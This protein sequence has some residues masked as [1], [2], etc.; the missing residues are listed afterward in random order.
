MRRKDRTTTSLM[1]SR[2]ADQIHLDA[3][4]PFYICATAI[5]W[6]EPRPTAIV[7]KNLASHSA[8][9]IDHPYSRR[10]SI[11]GSSTYC[12]TVSALSLSSNGVVTCY[13]VAEGDTELEPNVS[14]PQKSKA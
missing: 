6:S 11:A 10:P 1:S 14:S 3:G 8:P 13:L 5:S 12:Q 7:A 2:L 4:D 9:D